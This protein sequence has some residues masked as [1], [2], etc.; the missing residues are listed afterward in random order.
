MAWTGWG[1]ARSRLPVF[2]APQQFAAITYVR[3]NRLSLRRALFTVTCHVPIR[4]RGAASRGGKRN[5]SPEMDSAI[6]CE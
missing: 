2:S 6:F 5:Y 4:Q 1:P 3:A